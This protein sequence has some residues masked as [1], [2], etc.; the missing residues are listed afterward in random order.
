MLGAVKLSK[1]FAARACNSCKPDGKP[2]MAGCMRQNHKIAHVSIVPATFP[3]SN[4]PVFPCVGND[5]KGAE[6]HTAT[7]LQADMHTPHNHN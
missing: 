3:L 6:F 2:I 7:I 5:F 1:L 4:R